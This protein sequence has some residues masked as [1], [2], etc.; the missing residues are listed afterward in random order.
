MAKK[1]THTFVAVLALNTEKAGAWKLDL[2][3]VKQD[4]TQVLH[5]SISAWKNLSA[6]KKYT[7]QM[8]QELTPR[9]SVK[10]EVKATDA[11]GKPTHLQ[12]TLI[13]KA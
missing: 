5:G 9:K 7:K 12:G 3:Q 6:A 4:E 8:V 13:Y 11:N 2:M 10:W 1:V